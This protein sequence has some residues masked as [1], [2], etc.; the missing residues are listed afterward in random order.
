MNWLRL[1]VEA[2]NALFRKERVEG[3]LDE[4][5]RFHL[6]MEMAKN[7]R[8][9]MSPQEARRAARLQLGGVEQVKEQVRDE[10]GSRP[11]EDLLMDLRYAGRQLRRSPGF[12]AVAI[13]TLALGIGANTAVFS[14]LHHVILSPLA[15]D[16]PGRLVRIY[17]THERYG[18]GQW[19]SAP[20]FLDYR[21]QLEGL[22]SVAAM[23]NYREMG[24]TLTGLG[25]P[26][27]VTMLPVSSDFFDVYRV[28]PVIGRRFVSEEERG[29][30][31]LAVLSHRL[32]MAL[33]GGDPTILSRR[34]LLDG[35][36][37]EV[38]GVLP[39]GFVDLVGADVDLWV[40]LELQDEHAREDRGDHYLSIIGRLRRGVTLDQARAQLEALAAS[41]AEQYPRNHADWSAEIVPLH[42]NVVGN[43][44]AMLYLLFGAAGLVLLVACV[45]V[46][47]LF[48]ARN[49]TRERELAL[50][51]AIGAGRLR[52]VRQLFTESI[53]V[54]LLGGLAGLALAYWGV[55]A[56]LPLGR[57][58][59][60]RASE[61]TFDATLFVFALGVTLL[62]VMLF[63]LAPA[64]QFTNPNLEGSLREHPRTSTG[65]TRSKRLRDV[66]VT[67]QVALAILLLIGAGLLLRSLHKL[68]RLDLGIRPNDVMTF[69]IHL[70]GPRYEDPTARIAFHQN[71]QARLRAHP[72]VEA[73]GA[74]SRLPVSG[75]YHSWTF[76]YLSAAGEVMQ[77]GGGADF[78]VI[79]GDYFEALDI[80][81][82]AGRRFE[83]TDDADAPY[84]AI[85]NEWLARRYYEGRDPLGQPIQ[86][87]GRVW[88]IVGVVEDVA[89]D[90]RGSFSPKIYLPHAQKGDDRNWPLTQVVASSIPR[91]DL[92]AIAHQELAA[93]D[94]GLVIHNPRSMENV[95]SSAIAR[96]R[97]GFLLL[98]L[99][100]AVA[101]SLAAV[102][103]YGVMAYNVSRR[104]REFGIRL[105]MGASPQAMRWHVF[106][107]GALLLG[108]GI[109]VGLLGAWAL[110]RL[111]G[112]WLFEVSAT[113]PLTF[114]AVPIFLALTALLAGYVP[115]R[116]ATRADPVEV[117]RDE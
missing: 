30:A 102:G 105:A 63:G 78:R 45:N 53:S 46:A 103:M 14:I 27:R 18:R 96:E 48:L 75:V 52:L 37:Y 12:A 89:H 56:L 57:D 21:A 77:H 90:G 101:F 10:R 15:Y 50:R 64:L 29:S 95:S 112:S 74:I 9:G 13:L 109:T 85:I 113:D 32:W 87:D 49:V 28:Q 25:V 86:V 41:Q 66:L 65:G 108:T 71:Y 55:G 38:I 58:A 11:L 104:A 42:T 20:A 16:E 115:S 110:S 47:G 7:L 1:F 36:A 99:F 97:F 3:E 22:E 61:V 39:A 100:A 33:S 107:H 91:R 17:Q 84:V 35:D 81:L 60:P 114:S 62:T 51:A 31:R 43:V 54:A 8:A 34:L 70:G 59:L 80:R 6:E 117:L 92:L 19:V 83:R 24:F 94:P 67:S 23:Y 88:E 82:L 98:G 26:R 69:E 72:G 68:Q 40:P 4:E 73:L 106:R 116:R 111:L 79:E 5:L 2:F 76:T 93:T 44:G